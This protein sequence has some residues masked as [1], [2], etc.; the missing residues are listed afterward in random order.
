MKRYICPVCEHELT[1]KS[2]CPE[3][4]KIVRQPWVYDG[5]LPNEY[6]GDYL[7]HHEDQHPDRPCIE[8]NK[9]RTCETPQEKWHNQQFTNAQS[10][11]TVYKRYEGNVS[12]GNQSAMSGSRNTSAGNQRAVSGGRST[13][14]GSQSTAPGSQIW[15]STGTN[16][17]STYGGRTYRSTSSN[18]RKKN[19]AV[20]CGCGCLVVVIAIIA[21]II[22]AISSLEMNVDDWFEMIADESVFADWDDEYW[23]S[24]WKEADYDDIM[25]AGV[26]CNGYWHYPVAGKLLYNELVTIAETEMGLVMTAN[27][28][29]MDN[30]MYTDSEYGDVTYYDTYRYWDWAEGYFGVI[31]DT[32][33]DEVHYVTVYSLEPGEVIELG[34][35]VLE[36]VESG[37]VSSMRDQLNDALESGELTDGIIYDI[38]NSSIWFYQDSADESYRLEVSPVSE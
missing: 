20:G 19:S 5:F 3:C 24:E 4:R 21:M 22:G 34:M 31:C 8:P 15:R 32:V 16:S 23:G 33:T 25:S 36:Q 26:A 6:R 1:A 28:E 35:R 2:Y 38:G 9:S 13:S 17:G 27:S 11:Q 12:T 14:A 10:S 30:G 29:E 37:D 18:S 7:R